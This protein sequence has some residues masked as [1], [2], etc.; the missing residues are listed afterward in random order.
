M[1]FEADR[2]LRMHQHTLPTFPFAVYMLQVQ[3]CVTHC[4]LSLSLFHSL[5]YTHA[6]VQSV[7]VPLQGFLN[8]LVY[9]WTREDFLYIITRNQNDIFSVDS[10]RSNNINSPL[11][12]STNNDDDRG[13]VFA[14]NSELVSSMDEQEE[15]D[16]GP[17]YT[18]T[19][20]TEP[21]QDD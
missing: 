21:E 20:D 6:H 3:T 17:L 5:A 7:T 16:R 14:N 1:L 10:V 9:G 2:R 11:V 4:S 13:D 12:Q 15:F 18:V 8:A 19:E